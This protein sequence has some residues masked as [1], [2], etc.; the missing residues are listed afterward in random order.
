MPTHHERLFHGMGAGEELEAVETPWAV[1][2]A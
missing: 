2:V 1:S